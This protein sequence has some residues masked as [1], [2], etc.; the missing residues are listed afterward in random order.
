MGIQGVSHDL[1]GFNANVMEFHGNFIWIQWDIT[2]RNE[3]LTECW[4][5]KIGLTLFD[6]VLL[7]L[8]TVD[9]VF[10]DSFCKN[11]G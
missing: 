1:M 5:N 7:E 11:M 6:R 4:F 3:S 10:N 9:D 8:L 2:H